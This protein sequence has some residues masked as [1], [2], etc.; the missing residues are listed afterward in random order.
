MQSLAPV[1]PL[2]LA[3]I[4]CNCAQA[5]L[6]CQDSVVKGLTGCGRAGDTNTARQV[7]SSETIGPVVNILYDSWIVRAFELGLTV[8]VPRIRAAYTLIGCRSHLKWVR[9]RISQNNA[10]RFVV[11]KP[12]DFEVRVLTVCRY[13][14]L[15]LVGKCHGCEQ[16]CWCSKCDLHDD[17]EVDCGRSREGEM[18]QQWNDTGG[19][20]FTIY[21]F[22]STT[23]HRAL[24]VHKHPAGACSRRSQYTLSV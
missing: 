4:S 10:L 3:L 22:D 24:Q 14:E 17:I 16:K 1:E 9:E 21:M 12:V 18:V 8:P 7:M 15:D 13:L 5:Y 19:E 6:A 2:A 11:G 20:E 23:L